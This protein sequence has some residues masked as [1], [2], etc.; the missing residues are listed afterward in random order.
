MYELVS[1][2]YQGKPVQIRSLAVQLL[3]TA[4]RHHAERID[5]VLRECNFLHSS[6]YEL[7]S[8]YGG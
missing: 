4:P 5:S 1:F 7:V 6:L 3:P 2:K 8:M